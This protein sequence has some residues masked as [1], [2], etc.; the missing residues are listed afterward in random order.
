[1][2]DKYGLTN[3]RLKRWTRWLVRELM[4][5]SSAVLMNLSL[6]TQSVSQQ[7]VSLLLIRIKTILIHKVCLLYHLDHDLS[8]LK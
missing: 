8:L 7:I 4:R 6:I 2:V 1:M 3:H 5:L